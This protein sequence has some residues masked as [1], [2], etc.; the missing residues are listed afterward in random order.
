MDVGT[1]VF[2]GTTVFVEVGLGVDVL[3]GGGGATVAQADKNKSNQI[4]MNDG[5]GSVLLRDIYP[6]E[7]PIEE[8][9]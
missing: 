1:S 7:C 8:V 6:R 5:A 2:V 9:K 4:M 3:V